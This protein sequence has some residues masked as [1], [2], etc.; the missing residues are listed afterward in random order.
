[1]AEPSLPHSDPWG[2]LTYNSHNQGQ[3]TYNSHNQG[4]LY[5]ASWAICGAHSPENCSWLGTGS[6]L[7][8][9]YPQGQLSHNAQVRSGTSY[10]HPSDISISWGDSL[11]E[12]HMPGLW[13]QQTPCCFRATDPDVAHCG[14]TGQ[15][16][17]MVPGDITGYSHQAVPHYPRVSSSVC[18]HCAH[19][20]LFLFHFSITYLLLLVRSLSIW[21]HLRS[22]LRSAMPHLCIVALGKDHLEH[23]LP[24]PPPGTQSAGLVVISG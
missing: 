22:D 24:L 9:S 16:P 2:Q 21:G 4:Q 19:I 17:T 11:D 12:G 23:D 18:L 3:L 7:L 5:C 1:M 6:A 15:D 20:L 8:L 13:W 10:A 14:S